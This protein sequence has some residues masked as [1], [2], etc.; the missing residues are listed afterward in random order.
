MMKIFGEPAD[1]QEH[2]GW[3][4]LSSVAIALTPEAMDTFARFVA[5]A[6]A[7]MK[8]LGAAYDHVHFMDFCKG[9]DP[10]WPDI[11]LTRVY[12]DPQGS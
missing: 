9:W 10:A 2:E 11:Q 8:R 3:S 6:A 5:H 12:E 1:V 4:E 7:E